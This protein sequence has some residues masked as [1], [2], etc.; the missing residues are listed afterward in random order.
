[1]THRPTRRT[2]TT[3][4]A[5][6]LVLWGVNTPAHA[7]S[8][9]PQ[10]AAQTQTTWVAVAKDDEPLR[11]GDQDIYYAVANLA[12]GTILQSE[13]TS[14]L[15]TKVRYP[16][17][18]G[19]YVPADEAQAI[20][21]G[22]TIRLTT[23]SR[24]RAVSLLRGLEGSWSPVFATPIPANTELRVLSIERDDAGN[25]TA[26]KVRPPVHPSTS[27]HAIAYI[28][29]DALRDAT[30]AEIEAHTSAKPTPATTTSSNTNV[31]PEAKPQAQAQ[32]DPEPT[33]APPVSTELLDDT[34]LP[35][36]TP[37][38]Q[39]AAQP[40]QQPASEPAQ[41]RN[42]APRTVD[43]AGS[44][45]TS[46][47]EQLESAFTRARALPRAELDQAL[48]ELRAEYQRAIDDAQGDE[49]LVTSLS[50]R[51]AWIDLRIETRD[52]RRAIENALAQADDQTQ[53]LR[54]KIDQWESSR[55][56]ALVGTLSASS[57]YTGDPLPLLFRVSA[58][59]PITGIDRTVGY[60]APSD[61]ADPRRF[62]GKLVGIVGPAVRDDQLGRSVVRAS[63]IVDLSNQ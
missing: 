57:V 49:G 31:E 21:T 62:L 59:D 12:Q 5:A 27:T 60:V 26:Y 22:D 15:Y 17:D 54:A 29:T 34:Q 63:R 45:S 39:P 23:E 13:G 10:P 37:E 20:G 7:S 6:I 43:S 3:L 55:A 11:C 38:S 35:E 47:L 48:S 2:A 46:S 28:R 53:A 42:T 14:A 51:L 52:A 4:A 44:I 36:T 61:T 19:A 40:E 33:D 50:Q 9:Q 16:A 18:L 41:I 24:L 58:P 8:A 56:Y 1:M 32:T 25:V 30:P